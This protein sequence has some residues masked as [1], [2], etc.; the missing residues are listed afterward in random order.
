MHISFVL[1]GG[2][3]ELANGKE[4]RA[5][6]LSTVVK[7]PGIVHGDEFG[8]DGAVM[9]QLSIRGAVVAD[10]VDDP[11]RARPWVWRHGGVSAVAFLR[12]LARG[13]AGQRR[14]AV[15]DDDVVD[16][17][18]SLSAHRACP[19]SGEP[20]RWLRDAAAHLDE[21]WRAGL[22]VREVADAANV[23]PV[24]LARC[25]RRWFGIGGADLMRRARLKQATKAIADTSQTMAGVAY[26]TGFADEA[27]L[28]R[29]FSKATGMTPARFRRLGREIDGQ[30]RPRAG[31]FR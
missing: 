1:R 9:A 18:A 12:I 22:S 7:D 31:L 27:H 24:Y 26:A 28:C 16:L 3:R 30:T 2:L 21:G 25:L 15:D 6:P 4:E 19:P 11:G 5:D 14:F 29:E 20:P 23:H 10:L 13:R 8:A 17:L